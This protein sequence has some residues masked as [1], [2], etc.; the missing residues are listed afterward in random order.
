MI[1]AYVRVSTAEQ[2]GSSQEYE[3][4]QWAEKNALN[5]GKLD[6]RIGLGHRSAQQTQTWQAH[7]AD[8]AGRSARMHGDLPAGPQYADDHVHPE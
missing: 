1:Y 6:R 2:S 4:R 7:P 8:A 5:I 3:I